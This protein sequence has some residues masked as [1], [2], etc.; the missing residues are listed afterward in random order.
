MRKFLS[1]LMIG[2]VHLMRERFRRCSS[3]LMTLNN[4]QAYMNYEPV[5]FITQ[6][7]FFRQL[8]FVYFCAHTFA[9]GYEKSKIGEL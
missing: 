2:G 5:N 1:D 9:K 8:N 3:I 6:R 7:F 4:W